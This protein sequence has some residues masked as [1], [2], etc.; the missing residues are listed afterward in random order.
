MGGQ[1]AHGG[2]LRDEAGKLSSLEEP[3]RPCLSLDLILT[4]MFSH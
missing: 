4:V 3:H 1:E 2:R